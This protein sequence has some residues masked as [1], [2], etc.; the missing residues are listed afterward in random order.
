MQMGGG[1]DAEASYINSA[2]DYKTFY[3]LSGK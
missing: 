1:K 3:N 2:L